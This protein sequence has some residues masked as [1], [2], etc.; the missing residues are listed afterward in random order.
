MPEFYACDRVKWQFARTVV[1]GEAPVKSRNFNPTHVMS[2]ESNSTCFA[3]RL[4]SALLILA[5]SLFAGPRSRG[6]EHLERIAN[7]RRFDGE[8]RPIL[9]THCF[10]CHSGAKPKGDF[11]LD[12]LT[13]D[14]ADSATCQRWLAVAER[15][16]AGE[17]PPKAKPRPSTKDVQTL[18][19]WINSQ[20]QVALAARRATQG[21][22]VLRR[23]NRTEYENTVRDLLGVDIELKDMLPLDSSAAGFDNVGGALHT[24]SFL[25]EKYL[26]AANLAL[27]E[28]IANRAQPKTIFKRYVLK[29][30]H[31]IRNAQEKV[32]RASDK[33]VVLFTSSPWEALSISDFWPETRGRYRFRIS[34]ST[35][36]SKDNRPVTFRVWAGSGGMGGAP[37]HLVGYFDAPLATPKVFEFVEHVEPHTGFSILPYGLAG[38]SEVDKIGAEHWTGPGLAV[39]WVEIE[40]P[41]NDQWPP[42]SHRRLFGGLKQVKSSTN[43]GDRYEVTSTNPRADAERSLAQ[44]CPAGISPLGAR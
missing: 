12:Q 44:L 26:E 6:A 42:E 41:L 34:A 39:Q 15:V 37:G 28:A 19:A 35:I 17:M 10:G 40:G 31:S 7:S 32:F 4:L 13:P 9:A 16:A 3:I 24:S 23:L 33:E 1:L 43:Y 2:I 20:S 5:I 21:R 36:Q 14:F 18:T 30:Q 27:D 8:I 25:M 29:D 11:R 38:A 22:V